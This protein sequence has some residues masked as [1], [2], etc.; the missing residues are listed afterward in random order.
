[1][2]I[3]LIC[4]L[5]P[6][7]PFRDDTKAAPK[8]FILQ[9]LG[10]GEKGRIDDRGAKGR[11]NRLHRFAHGIKEGAAG[12]LHQMPA[13][14][15]LLRPG[16]RLGG[17]LAISAATIARDDPDGR[18]LLEPVLRSRLLAVR[19]Q[20]DRLTALKIADD[21]AVALVAAEGEI[22]NADDHEKIVRFLGAS[23]DDTQQGIVADR[24][25]EPLRHRSART[26]AQ[27]KRKIMHDGVKTAGSP[28]A[29]SKQI[30]TVPLG[31]DAPAAQDRIAPETARQDCQ[32]Y[33]S[34]AKRQ[35]FWVSHMAALS[36]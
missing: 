10:M 32:R 2:L 20:F 18:I 33:Q 9:P 24:K 29:R 23:P 4:A 6:P 36:P 28:G 19:L 21:R 7:T 1:M 27:S 34:T 8:A 15:H 35:I 25:H 17:R 31:E 30:I 13:I 16:Q 12:V 26:P 22:V 3:G 5:A 14:C 11:T